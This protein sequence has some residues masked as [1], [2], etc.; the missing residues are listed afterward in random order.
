MKHAVPWVLLHGWLGCPEDWPAPLRAALDAVAPVHALQLPGHG[1]EGSDPETLSASIPQAASD[2]WAHLDAMGI[3][4]CRLVGYSMGGRLAYAMTAAAPERVMGLATIGAHPGL[5]EPEVRADRETEDAA[6][7]ER[8]LAEGLPTFLAHWYDLP[9]WGP[10]RSHPGYQDLLARRLR[11]DL[12]GLAATAT[13]LGLGRQADYRG[14]LA[15]AGVPILLLHGVHD[16][17]Y[18]AL[19]RDMAALLPERA[20][21]VPIAGAW[22][23]AHLDQ[24][25]AVAKAL[26]RFAGGSARH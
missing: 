10:I 3:E 13:R 9:L 4:R 23:A 15:E 17:R 20:Q 14:A 6:R 11:G 12:Q 21:V 26:C 24:P 8:L 22:H 5:D 25:E 18:G 16:E 19:L 2:L 7:A 1:P